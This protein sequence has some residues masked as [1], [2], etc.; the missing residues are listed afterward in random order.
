MTH[1]PAATVL[2]SREG[3][4]VR[5]RW[6]GSR[7]VP[8]DDIATFDAGDLMTSDGMTFGPSPGDAEA[9][10]VALAPPVATGSVSRDAPALSTY[11]SGPWSPAR[12]V[13]TLA[14]M[15]SAAGASDVHI[16]P[17]GH[18]YQT[19]L[20]LVGQLEDFSTFSLGDGA[21]LIAA[22][23]HDA[24]CLPYRSDLVQEGRIRR[25]G[26]AA[27]VRASFLPTALGERA[28]LRLF[29]S[30]IPLGSLGLP[31]AVL[32]GLS[33]ALQ[34]RRGL[35]LVAG[36]SG[37]GKTTTLYA[38]LAHLA[39]GS[40]DAHLSIEDP[41]EQRL[42]PAGIPVDQIELC[43]ERGLTAEAVLV[44]ALRQDVN[45]LA[46]GEI[47]TRGE[48]DLALQAA[49]TGRLVLAGIHAGSAAEASR[50][51]VDLG[52]D[53]VTLADTLRA[54]LFQRLATIACPACAPGC[55]P[56]CTVCRGTRRQRVPEAELLTFGGG[57]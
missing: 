23:K 42:R 6:F 54:V 50:R 22:L 2:P 20:R 46:V 47:R 13:R 41:V 35:V 12:A 40:A 26:I 45:V 29:G 56:T 25:D 32:T 14:A 34:G 19:R 49:H 8:F 7:F 1:G 55:D 43:P 18:H 30:L 38:A 33:S 48:A 27:D 31:A 39:R 37:A 21:R 3:I 44:G 5:N 24:G 10:R 4:I 9:V 16:E 17:H 28:A 11:V 53:P 51:M 57:R 52:A 36:P 15:A